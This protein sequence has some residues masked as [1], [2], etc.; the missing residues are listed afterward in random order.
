MT[1]NPE[2]RIALLQQKESG[3]CRSVIL[4]ALRYF[5]S[6]DLNYCIQDAPPRMKAIEALKNWNPH[7]IIAHTV[8]RQFT[9]TIIRTGL[10]MVSTTY[11]YPELPA[12]VIDVDHELVGEMAARYFIGKGFK[13]YAYFGSQANLFSI[14]REIGFRSYLQANGL[15]VHTLHTEVLPLPEPTISWA[16]LDESIAAWLNGLPKPIAILASNDHPGRKLLELCHRLR[17]KVPSDVAVL[18]VDN[19]ES[20]CRMATPSLSSIAIPGEK[21]GYLAAEKI[22]RHLDHGEPLDPV[23]IKLEPLYC[24]ARN[25]TDVQ[26]CLDPVIR[27]SLEIISDQ[28]AQGLTVDLLT[29]QVG[30]SRRA[31]ERKF[32]QHLKSSILNQIHLAHINLAQQLLIETEFA[33]Q[34][35]AERCGLPSVRR[36]NIIFRKHTGTTPRDYRRS[37]R[38]TM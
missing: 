26:S 22:H 35:V 3:Y 12:P 36:F 8:D 1:E 38:A 37:S 31:L 24:I 6:H 23:Y 27:R 18:G 9:E 4:G 19:D 13:N 15:T 32:K 33:I 20:E 25:S 21:I 29:R 5:E 34:E 11:S 10:P 14:H 2:R 7:G 17:I 28:V 30:C 16:E